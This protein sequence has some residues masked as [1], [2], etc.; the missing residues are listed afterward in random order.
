[1]EGLL[2]DAAPLVH[3]F[4]G[5]EDAAALG[6]PVEFVHHRL[7]DQIGELF[8]DEGALERVLIFR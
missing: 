3:S 8:D 6:E 7:L 1:M 2:L 4:H 5:A